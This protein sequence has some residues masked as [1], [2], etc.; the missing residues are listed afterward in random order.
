MKMIFIKNFKN[1]HTGKCTQ[2][3]FH[4]VLRIAVITSM[5][6]FLTTLFITNSVCNLLCC[7]IFVLNHCLP[8][9]T[10]IPAS[11]LSWQDL[12]KFLL[13]LGKHGSHVKILIKILLR[14]YLF[15]DRILSRWTKFWDYKKNTISSV[16]ATE[17]QSK[18]SFHPTTTISTRFHNQTA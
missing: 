12:A 8:G 7:S 17:T 11:W 16:Q 6:V 1:F 14:K 9:L 4:T 18:G 5:A 2:N 3:D 15:Q 10:L 13:H